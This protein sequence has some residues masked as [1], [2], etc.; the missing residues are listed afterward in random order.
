MKLVI[1]ITNYCIQAFIEHISH[2]W[3]PRGSVGYRVDIRPGQNI[4]VGSSPTSA[5]YLVIGLPYKGIGTVHMFL[6]CMISLTY[7]WP[8]ILVLHADTWKRAE[9][10]KKLATFEKYKQNLNV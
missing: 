6:F 2:F 7:S 5:L 9:I 3:E 4:T 1:R 8:Y 10:K